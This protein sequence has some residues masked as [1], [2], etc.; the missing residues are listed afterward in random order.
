MEKH[1]C[2]GCMEEIAQE[3]VCPKCGFDPAEYSTEPHQLSP[4]TLLRERYSVGRVL[5]EGGFG[6]TYVGRDTVLDL[7][8]AVKEFYM[9]G[10]VNRNTTHSTTVQANTGTYGETFTKN[11]EKF[12]GEA[13]VLA[14]FASEEGI[15]GIR[16]YFQENNTAYIVMD[17]LQGETLRSYIDRE[18][19]LSAERAWN[20]LLPVI[21]SLGN[22]H[23]HNVIHRDIS[24]D[25]I[26]LTDNGKVKLLD[27]GAAREVSNTDIKSLSIILKPGYAPEEQYRSKG[28]QG[29]WTDIY[30]MCATLYR[31]ITGVVP[32]DSMERMFEDKLPAPA[33]M[34]CTCSPAMSNVI[35]KGL[36]VRLADRYQSIEELMADMEKAIADP[37]NES[38]AAPSAP[39][40]A[41]DPNRT[42]YVGAENAATMAADPMAT[43]YAEPAPVKTEP[44]S[45][46]KAAPK[47]K[48][49]PKP[50]TME[51]AKT[52]PAKSGK[53]KKILIPVIIVAAVLVIGFI[54]GGIALIATLG[55][56]GGNNV[57]TIEEMPVD[58]SDFRI[59]LNGTEIQLPCDFATFEAAGWIC[60]DS[61]DLEKKVG[62]GSSYGGY[63]DLTNGYGEINVF[64]ANYSH[65]TLK[66]RDCQI[67]EIDIY[68][69]EINSNY[70]DEDIN[71]ASTDFGFTVGETTE[72]DFKKNAPRG[73]SR[74]SDNSYETYTY[75]LDEDNYY[76][77][78]FEHGTLTSIKI[79]HKQPLA[80]ARENGNYPHETKAPK[81][82]EDE[83]L[84]SLNGFTVEFGINGYTV[85]VPV[86]VGE[87]VSMG[88]TLEK[89][90]PF[91]ESNTSDTVYLRADTLTTFELQAYNPYDKA[92]VID[93]CFIGYIADWDLDS[94]E[95]DSIK[96]VTFHYGENEFTYTPFAETTTQELVDFLTA[97]G[98]AYEFN[99]DG[100][101]NFYPYTAENS[102]IQ[103]YTYNEEL[104]NTVVAAEKAY[105]EFFAA[106]EN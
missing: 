19:K 27:F 82:D 44:K 15:V 106:L 97:N 72:S 50:K 20:I 6:I 36:A 67:Y 34:D 66:A 62:P 35:M 24:P 71:S 103:V 17:F 4:G 45:E 29:P 31:C 13:R 37:N 60:A 95:A 104:S 78:T 33:N 28:K 91:L 38:I 12:L 14:K 77:F 85:P 59:N 86:T 30:A 84:H 57:G 65:D 99:T 81:Y 73:Y 1:I 51:P 92:M 26:M 3:G 8:V 74:T 22:V 61:A 54:A 80:Q 10:Y 83:F 90:A 40:A 105:R 53:K 98:I 7:K 47:P 39:A 46:P 64:Y 79:S 75:A 69:F 96:T 21:K 32:D 23:S 101:I 18:G 9:S 16:D 5:G 87:L 88:Y 63:A 70:M 41:A 89:A 43:V 56:N 11:R 49:E 2:F 102:K 94:S 100:S 68:K 25:N 93:E 48:T 58:F 52:E 42:V 76:A 55:G